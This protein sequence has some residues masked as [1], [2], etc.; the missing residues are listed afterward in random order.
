MAKAPIVQAIKMLCEEK[1]LPLDMVIETVESALAA[2][3]RK[4]FGDPSQNLKVE[5][6]ME[7]GDFDVSDIKEVVE[8]RDLDAEA[9]EIAKAVEEGDEEAKKRRFNP[10]T[11]IMLSDAKKGS[12]VGDEL[13]TALDVPDDFGRMA[14]QTAK[15]VVIQRLREAERQSVFDEFKSK[16]GEI[17]AGFVQRKEG[18]NF[19]VDLGSSIGILPL[20]GQVRSDNYDGSTRMHFYVEKVFMGTKGAEIRLSRSHPDMVKHLFEFEIPEIS[21]GAIE[22]VSI[23]REAGSRTKIAVKALQE[24]IDPIGSCVGQRGSRVQTII[25]ELGGEKIDIIEFDDDMAQ[26]IENALAPAKVKGIE[27]NEEDKIAVVEVEDDNLSLAIGKSGQ[28]VRLAARLTGWRVNIQGAG[29]DADEKDKESAEK[30]V[31]EDEAVEANE[32]AEKEIVAEEEVD[33]KK[34]E[35]DSSDEGKIEEKK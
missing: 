4:D 15:Q 29:D 3:Y 12:K 18:R 26:Y 22:I 13:K 8:D 10:K 28:N 32:E 21:S 23:A 20:E 24:G 6:N 31:V 14:A 19:L 35:S 1:N 5:L 7:T 2:A 9:E 25:S 33:S 27:L 30:V 34:D 11:E 16:E 17:L